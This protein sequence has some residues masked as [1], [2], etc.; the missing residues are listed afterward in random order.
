MA[1][2]GREILGEARELLPDAVALRRRIHAHPEL[3]L[4]LPETRA[5]V[6]EALAEIELEIELS[7]KTSGLV[8]T[9]RGERDGPGILLRA[10]MDA[11]S[12]PEDTGL[13]F[14]SKIPGRMHA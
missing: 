12:M 1:V 3:G 9:L 2:C 5:A 4:D 6:L 7:E 13:D 8:A 14:A 10:D 11:L